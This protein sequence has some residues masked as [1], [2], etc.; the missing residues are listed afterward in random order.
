MWV[1]F[2]GQRCCRSNGIFVQEITLADLFH[3]ALGSLLFEQL[4][5]GNLDKR[6]NVQRRGIYPN[7]EVDTSDASVADGGRTSRPDPRGRQY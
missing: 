2:V 5:L 6:P 1:R 4:G 7:L 3:L